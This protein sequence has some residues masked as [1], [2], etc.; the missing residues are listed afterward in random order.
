MKKEEKVIDLYKFVISV[1]QWKDIVNE[2]IEIVNSKFKDY[3]G[4]KVD[5]LYTA[6]GYL[7]SRATVWD[8]GK[9]VDI[10]KEILNV[11]DE[12]MSKID[13]RALD[14]TLNEWAV[15]IVCDNFSYISKSDYKAIGVDHALRLDR[16]FDAFKMLVGN[17]F[18]VYL[19]DIDSIYKKAFKLTKSEEEKV[20]VLLL[21]DGDFNKEKSKIIARNEGYYE[22]RSICSTT[23]ISEMRKMID[24][25]DV[26]AVTEGFRKKYN[27][28][29]LNPKLK[30]PTM[31]LG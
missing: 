6:I 20:K 25:C 14:E 21:H 2:A 4:N 30:H 9:K 28:I 22:L 31:Y 13:V 1:Q 23:S 5:L 17:K 26:V 7:P 15:L 3:T 8:D 18:N 10:N 19:E 29:T 12:S 27:F 24:S 16:D 11:K